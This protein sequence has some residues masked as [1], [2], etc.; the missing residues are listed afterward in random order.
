MSNLSS[1]PI[2]F[3]TLETL[4]MQ[5]LTMEFVTARLMHEVSKRRENE[6]QG[7]DAAMVSTQGR[8][9][10]TSTRKDTKTC[11]YCGKP[12]H[13][14]RFYFKAKNNKEK[15]NANKAKDDDDYA[16]ATKDGDHC[17]AICK[18]IMD[19]GATKHMT[20]H[21]AA[22]DMYEVIPTRNVHMG[23][24]SICEGCVEGKQHH[25]PFPSD[26]GMRAT[27]PLEIVHSDVCGPMRTTSLDVARYFVTYIDDFSRKVCVYLLKSKGECL[28]KFK[29]FK[30]L[31]EKQSEY[32]I[33]VFRS[34]NGGEYISKG[35]Q[36][37]LK[38]HDIEKQTSTPYRPQQ[39]GVADRANRTLVEMARS[40]LHAQNLKKSLW[41]KAVV[42]AVYTRNRC[43]SRA[44][45]SITP[46]E[47]WSGRKPCISHM[48]VFGCIAYAMVSDEKRG[49]L[50]AKG[51]KC[52]FLGYCEGTKAYRLMCVQ[53]KK[54]IKCRDV[55]FMEDNTSVGNDLKMRP[56][57]RNETPNVVIVDTSSKSPC[58]DDDAKEDPSNEEA[59][60][61][62]G[63][64]STP[65]TPSKDA[66]TSGE[67][68]G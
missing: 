16:F 67:Q 58:V 51:T 65:S 13:I 33:K 59:T 45:P 48:R 31:V 53:S 42:N 68:E 47:A 66:S 40:M 44:L 14:A 32:K 15:E 17:K 46:E 9:G 11:Y 1:D 24:N 30:A 38:A 36:G 49:K 8:G 28:E 18:W 25:K 39:N 7:G 54:I 12:G 20:P 5:A 43:P 64:S 3:N 61:T 26:G 37:F 10:T 22:F 21:T 23:D 57:G 63:C 29:E 60:P 56:S 2:V 55:E 4:P 41:A 62:P 35:F 27:K 52:L 6:P 34:D 19:S 50:D